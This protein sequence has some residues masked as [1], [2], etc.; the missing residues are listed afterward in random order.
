MLRPEL[1]QGPPAF[2]LQLSAI[3]KVVEPPLM[4]ALNARLQDNPR[5]FGANRAKFFNNVESY[6]A[7]ARGVAQEVLQAI[8]F[9]PRGSP[10]SLIRKN[11]AP[12]ID[13]IHA[14]FKLD[15]G[16]ALIDNHP[17][18]KEYEWPLGGAQVH[19][20]SL[21]G[22]QGETIVKTETGTA[23]LRFLEALGKSKVLSDALP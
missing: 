19:F 1:R 6:A 23:S 8:F 15:V 11:I 17:V 9:A 5:G 3:R 14:M 16:K 10:A 7:V 13:A 2:I 22:A 4:A 21:P 18:V 20:F 12:K